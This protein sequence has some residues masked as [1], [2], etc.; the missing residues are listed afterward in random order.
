MKNIL[1]LILLLVLFT[2]C[3][4]TMPTGVEEVVEFESVVF[5]VTGKEVTDNTFFVEGTVKNTGNTTFTPT[6]YMEAQFYTDE[7][8][9]LKLGGAVDSFNFSLEKGETT[10]WSLKYSNSDQNLDNYQDFGVG[11]FRAYKK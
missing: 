7:A 9:S 6:W 3:E 1:A 2:G 5:V 8:K 4:E 10:Q 11:N